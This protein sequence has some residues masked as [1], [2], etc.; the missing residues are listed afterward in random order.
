MYKPLYWDFVGMIEYV[1][2]NYE[3]LANKQ[4]ELAPSIHE[5]W[6]WNRVVAEHFD[7]VESRLML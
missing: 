4:F 5:K 2:A 7:N 3:D 6:N 1:V